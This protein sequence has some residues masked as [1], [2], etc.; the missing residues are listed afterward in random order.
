[1]VAAANRPATAEIRRAANQILV[2]ILEDFSE[3]T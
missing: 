2:G 1:M 3:N